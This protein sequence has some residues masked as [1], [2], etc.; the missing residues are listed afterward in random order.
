MAISRALFITKYT[1]NFFL[2][3]SSESTEL[4]SDDE[5]FCEECLFDRK[6]NQESSLVVFVE[7]ARAERYFC[8]RDIILIP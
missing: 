7:L 8:R 2:S 6:F 1:L 4:L 5:L 3:F